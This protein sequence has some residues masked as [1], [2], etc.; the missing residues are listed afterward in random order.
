MLG[1]CFRV[2][3]AFGAQGGVTLKPALVQWLADCQIYE[4]QPIPLRSM[5]LPRTTAWAMEMAT[6]S[7]AEVAGL[8]LSSLMGAQRGD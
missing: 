7:S 5:A 8:S 4:L 1:W 6:P 2:F 3:G